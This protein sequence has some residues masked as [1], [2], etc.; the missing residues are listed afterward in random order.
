MGILISIRPHGIGCK[1]TWSKIYHMNRATWLNPLICQLQQHV[2]YNV[3][4]YIDGLFYIYKKPY[5][6][7]NQEYNQSSSV[8]TQPLI[9]TIWLCNIMLVD[10]SP[11]LAMLLTTNSIVSQYLQVSHA[12]I[13]CFSFFMHWVGVAFPS[14]STVLLTQLP[15]IKQTKIQWE[16]P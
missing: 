15:H 7:H 4:L 9:P 3:W 14:V 10:S 16:S 12:I 6:K 5:N 1:Q 8:Y 2:W 11:K 13:Y